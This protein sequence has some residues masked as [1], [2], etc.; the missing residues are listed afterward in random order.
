MFTIQDGRERFY[1]WDID[2]KL[3]VD[4]T[5]INEVHYCNRTGDC[6]LV[7]EVFE[8]N[9]Q[10]VVDVP[11]ILLQT[12]WRIR[13]Y[14]Y[15]SKYTKHE[16]LFDVNPRT[17]PADYIYT[18]TEL[19]N[20]ADLEE[21]LTALEENAVPEELVRDAV[22][23]YL[24]E[25]PFEAGATAEEKAQI[26]ANS[27]AIKELQEKE[28]DLTGYATEEYVNSAIGN[29]EIPTP[30]LT[31][32]ATEQFVTDAIGAIEIPEVDLTAYYNKEEINAIMGSYITDIDTLVGG[33]E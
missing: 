9:G 5:S 11:N 26:E 13:V 24:A 1:Q 10:R 31:G 20:Y 22:E 3:I 14:A 28:V 23:D 8:E 7:C 12:A 27:A 19:K 21:R 15:D 2:R 17:K 25:N 32:Y 4:D 29:I 30:D 6:S 33:A 18:E 16:E